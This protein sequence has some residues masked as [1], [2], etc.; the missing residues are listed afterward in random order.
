MSE[1]AVLNSVTF[2][3][4]YGIMSNH[5]PLTVTVEMQ[6]TG[7]TRV[8]EANQEIPSCRRTLIQELLYV[9]VHT[10]SYKLHTYALLTYC[11]TN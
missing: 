1:E 4:G 7:C 2:K 3:A 9:S 5:M 10:W 8:F 6:I 11:Y